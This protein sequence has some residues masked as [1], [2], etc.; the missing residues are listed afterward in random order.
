[1]IR[2]A[3]VGTS[4]ITEKFLEACRLTGRYA[5]HTAYS[6]GQESGEHFARSQ[7]FQ[8][9]STDLQAVA[10]DP[11]IDA[12]YIAT[13]NSFH[14]PQSKLFLENGKHVI[15]EKPIVTAYGE[16]DELLSL[17]RRKGVVYAEAIMSRHSAGRQILKGALEKIGRISQVRLDFCQLSSRYRAFQSGEK[18]NIFDMSLAAGTLMD[19]GVYAVYAAVDLFGKPKTVSADAVFAANG[20]DLA[21]TALFGYENFT[22]ALTYS[23]IGQGAL[24]SEIIGDNGVVKIGSVS[25]YAGIS[26]VQDGRETVLFGTPTRAEVMRGE[27]ERFAEYIEH[28]DAFAAEYAA[29]CE[30]TH[31]VHACMDLIKSKANIQYTEKENS[32]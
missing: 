7:G 12:V 1:M 22:A 4:A 6:R 19:L 32:R 8:K 31:T 18:V 17:A 3:T 30:L 13:P 20:A 26:L 16:Y 14:Y 2:L 29:V 23:K 25:Q 27:A 24:G 10:A 11:A 28:A 21:G 15:C 9:N 5:F